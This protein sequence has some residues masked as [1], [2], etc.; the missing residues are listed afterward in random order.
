M[1]DG[2]A[3]ELYFEI[4][5]A[6]LHRGYHVLAFEGPGQG[7]A[8]REQ[9]LYFRHDWEKVVTPV[10]DY[11]VSRVEVD[12]AR[13]ALIGYSFGGYLAPRA[14]AFEQRLAACV[15]NGGIYSFFDGA[16]LK[17][18][19]ASPWMLGEL[20]KDKSAIIDFGTRLMMHFN[21]EC[22]GLFRTAY[23]NLMWRP[24][25]NYLKNIR[26]T[27]WPVWLNKFIAQCWCAIRKGNNFSG[28]KP[29]SYIKN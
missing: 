23:G 14:A 3:E 7:E 16:V 25:I 4:A 10:V 26:D 12:P 9:N 24:P 19:P 8:L 20:K 29:R 2:T 13:I 22:A 17:N 21:T 15:A 27:L 18:K 6:A 11:L 1:V 28:N 5:A